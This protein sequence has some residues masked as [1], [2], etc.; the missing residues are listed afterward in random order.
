MPYTPARAGIGSRTAQRH[1][2]AGHALVS[3]LALHGLRVSRAAG[4]DTA[5]S[6]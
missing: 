3:L 2:R 1:R 5:S 6:A 4:A